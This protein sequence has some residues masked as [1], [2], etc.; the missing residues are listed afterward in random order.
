MQQEQKQ[1][2]VDAANSYIKDKGLSAN[3]LSRLSGVNSGYLSQMLRG[4]FTTVVNNKDV[5]IAD[6]WFA[7][8]ATAIDLPLTKQFWEALATPQFIQ[9]I[10]ALEK[11]K[12]R[13]D[14]A[15]LIGETGC[16]KTYSIDRFCARNPLHTYRVTV[17]SVYR[18]P[19]LLNELLEKLGIQYSLTDTNHK[20]RID[21][22][23]GK[24]NEIR[25]NGGF[26]IIIIDEGENLEMSVLKAI[27]ALYDAIENKCAMVLVGTE[28]LLVKLS[29]L[30][31]RNRDAIPQLYSRF[32]S[33]MR[34]INSIDKDFTIF[35]EKHVEDNGLRKLLA[36]V[37]ETYRDLYKYLVP[38]MR[39][40]D[41]NG[42]PLTENAFRLFHD[43]PKKTA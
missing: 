31:K 27:K 12:L 38:V 37:C 21:L 8:L 24:L 14:T 1:Q 11:T 20:K 41:T 40:C 22:I 42:T 26:P 18:L 29:N 33:G 10:S 39:E 5:T 23:S 25:H 43:M 17:S 36:N 9:V 34:V 30:R 32:K 3:D 28:Q 7:K 2:I 35:F 19:D 16:G 4:Q 13:G 6:Q 15:M